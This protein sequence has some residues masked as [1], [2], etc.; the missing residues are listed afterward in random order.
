MGWDGMGWDGMGWVSA[1]DGKGS[2]EWR[3]APLP[4]RAPLAGQ[5]GRARRGRQRE[6]QAEL[7]LHAAASS[8]QS[9]HARK[10]K[11]FGCS[12]EFMCESV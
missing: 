11:K 9:I 2:R 10:K 3:V 8:F 4:S 6:I 7:P 1:R 5:A 12:G